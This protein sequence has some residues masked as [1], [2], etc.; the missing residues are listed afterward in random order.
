MEPGRL[1][2]R[3][4]RWRSHGD[5]EALSEVI[6]G[7]SPE[8]YELAA[9]LAPDV[10]QAE[11]LVQAAFLALL[12]KPRAWDGK[13]PLVPW[14]VGILVNQARKSSRGARRSI[15]VERLA[16]RKVEPPHERALSS[17]LRT[18]I[19]TALATLPD[20]CREVVARCVL[21]D[22]RPIDVAHA[23]K[24]EPG[25]VRMQLL[26]GLELLRH[27]LPPSFAGALVLAGGRGEAA[28][29]ASL[30]ARAQAA[31]PAGSTSAI[32]AGV[33]GG[34]LM[35]TKLTWIGIAAA[36]A[37]VAWLVWPKDANP[38]VPSSVAAPLAAP[39]N[40]HEPSPEVRT[41]DDRSVVSTPPV[42]R[43]VPESRP[44]AAS[45]EAPGS[46]WLVGRVQGLDA[47]DVSRATL[48]AHGVR[49]GRRTIPLA[50]DGRFEID[51]SGFVAGARAVVA[52][53]GAT[54]P[55]DSPDSINLAFEHP[56]F[57][58]CREHVGGDS[59]PRALPGA[60]RVEV[61]RDL[62]VTRAAVV[63]GSV[64]FE[65]PRRSGGSDDTDEVRVLLLERTDSTEVFAEKVLEIGADPDGRF[66]FRAP[67]SDRYVVQA[68]ANGWRAV[69][70]EIAVETG[71]E[72]ALPPLVLERGTVELRGR[73]DLPPGVALDGVT[74]DAQ[75]LHRAQP[76]APRARLSYDDA[77]SY[78]ELRGGAA[79]AVQHANVG[80][81]GAFRLPGLDAGTWKLELGGLH[82]QAI[83]PRAESTI[84]L[85]PGPEVLVGAELGLVRARVERDGAPVANAHTTWTVP[86]EQGSTSA[87]VRTDEH[88]RVAVLVDLRKACVV[89]ASQREARS[90]ALSL[91]AAG[92]L[93]EVE[94]VLE[95]PREAPRAELVLVPQPAEN[96]P[97]E[98]EV[99]LASS[100]EQAGRNATARARLAQGRYHFTGLPS[101]RFRATVRPIDSTHAG[102]FFG[103]YVLPQELELSLSSGAPLE[104]SLTLEHGGRL[105]VRPSG[106]STPAARMRWKLFDAARR[107]VAGEFVSREESDLR[108][109]FH[110]D[111]EA[112]SLLHENAFDACLAPG[113]YRL[114]F[115]SDEWSAA[116]LDF[117]I[118]AD[119]TTSLEFAVRAR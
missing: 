1:E 34:L 50:S 27:A 87:T 21:A 94:L 92:R 65:P 89:S 116:P 9:R 71:R 113:R 56:D 100:S 95:L 7:A 37:L 61:H 75:L 33:L 88:G 2:Q 66:R 62:S 5:L 111:R 30:L 77:R 67:R 110:S 15:D 36:L 91:P 24:R 104:L 115:E 12:E 32:G 76:D 10:A 55:F 70:V 98:L 26:R 45:A 3:F 107:D 46:C 69:A 79:L 44:E 82:I 81:S 85:A 28:V 20:A 49:F 99:E 57:S 23:L 114:E 43:A 103:N 118:K 16:E 60:G 93:R 4:E 52:S 63:S 72:L 97:A 19:E 40:E 74:V 68:S 38:P 35:A 48:V 47:A 42:E 84:A 101:G 17:E 117:E 96:V 64:R 108:V 53:E 78:A 119:E 51:I 25:T 13:R 102:M 39:D 14:M 18:A 22:E 90:P 54:L 73:V 11:D 29:R 109:V 59:M 106:V 41:A 6:D 105:R 112:L 86:T 31:G 80:E 58:P 8:L 83:V